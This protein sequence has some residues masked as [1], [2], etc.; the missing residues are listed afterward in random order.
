MFNL[1]FHLWVKDGIH[2]P[3]STPHYFHRYA[4]KYLSYRSTDFLKLA[5]SIKMKVQLISGELDLQ[6]NVNS[7]LKVSKH[8][9]DP[10]VYIDP[11]GDHYGVLRPDSKTLIK[12]SELMQEKINE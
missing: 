1:E 6:A 4:T 5:E 11:K 9:K 10:A 2:L 3:F 8:L 12:I 7:T